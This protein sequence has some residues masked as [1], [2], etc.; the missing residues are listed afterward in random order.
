[1]A[2]LPS[3]S[4]SHRSTYEKIFQHPLSHNLNWKDVHSLLRHLADVQE[5]PNGNL[6][7][8]RHGEVL[9]LHP[10]R[11]K[12]VAEAD[13]VMALRHFLQRSESGQ[14]AAATS[15]ENCVLVIDHREAR[16]FRT[17]LANGVPQKILPPAPSE[18]FRHAPHSAEFTRGQEIPDPN[19]YF[20][21]IA[22]ALAGASEILVLG[23]GT[24]KSSEMEQFVNWM[25][26]HHA[27]QARKII[28][29]LVVDEHHLSEGQLLAKAREFFAGHPTPAS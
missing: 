25:E 9:V 10:S 17:E 15:S 7:V 26:R 24:G 20:A 21:P 18:Y 29:Q 8:S 3:L 19:T 28:G 14:P 23:T 13:E 6:K 12:D 4:G 5:E 16:I 2:D 22:Q 11:S 27:E 1:M